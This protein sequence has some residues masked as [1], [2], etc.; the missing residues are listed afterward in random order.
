MESPPELTVRVDVPH[1]EPAEAAVRQI[2]WGDAWVAF[3]AAAAPV[4]LIG[5]ALQLRF[6]G[7]SLPGEAVVRAFVRQ[8]VEEDGARVYRFQLEH[9][10]GTAFEA[11]VN[12]R[13]AFRVTPDEALPM[14]VMLR[15]PEGGRRV[16]GVVRDLSE[17]GLSALLGKE[18][19]W[20][21]ARATVLEV[22]FF[23]P[24]CPLR[25]RFRAEVRHR[26]LERTAVHYGMRFD[27]T[28][29][30]FGEAQEAVKAYVAE[31]QRA[32][33]RRIAPDAPEAA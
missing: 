8:R 10:D 9:G 27:E 5:Q 21:L 26:R 3:P 20:V 33:R 22:E 16:G 18:D 7:P 13:A 30:G 1:G 2:T 23:L 11:A 17:T 6:R 19:E 28:A 24:T 25:L 4:L 29:A 15:E 12:R 31:R 14:R 32:M